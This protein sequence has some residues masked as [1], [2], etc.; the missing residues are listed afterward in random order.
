MI[1]KETYQKYSLIHNNDF[2][3]KIDYS[4]KKKCPYCKKEKT[5]SEFSKHRKQK[6]GFNYHCKECTKHIKKEKGINLA[7]IKSRAKR[8]NIEFNI[9]QEDLFLPEYCPILNIK[10]N[11]DARLGSNNSPSVD[12]IDNSKGYIKGNVI[13]IS[14]LANAMKNA[15]TFDELKLFSKNILKLITSYENQGALGNITDIFPEIRK[16]NLGF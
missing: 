12:R 7:I 5:L 13:V 15:A 6:D 16:V 2:Y 9:I 11:Y 4:Q 14:R 1:N 8:K 3:E 10:I